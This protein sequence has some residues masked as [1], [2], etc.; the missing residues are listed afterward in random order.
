MAIGV[1]SRVLG[2]GDVGVQADDVAAAALSLARRFASGATV[3]CV[4]PR[5]PDHARHVAVEFVHPVVVGKRALPAVQISSADAVATLRALA[6]RGDIVVAIGA[7]GDAP[8]APLL[9]RAEPWGLTSVWIGAGAR[10][11]AGAADHVLWV[12]GVEPAVA[13][14]SG[15]FVLLY[16]LLW[17]LTHVVLEHPVPLPPDE[18]CTDEIC[19]TCSDEGTLAEVVSVLDINQAV[20]L[21]AGRTETI[22]TTLV[23][24]VAPG[25]LV[26]VHAGMAITTVDEEE[27]G[28]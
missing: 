4:S 26:V 25:A 16:H 18:G 3:W 19:I 12:D 10:P 11:A 8:L 6:D 5:W 22:D 27:G 2:S 7:A 1:P 15:A 9:R 28:R 24:D 14:R 20:V 13:S 17:E 21:A 23:D